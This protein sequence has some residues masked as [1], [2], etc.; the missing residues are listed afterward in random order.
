MIIT[1]GE[2]MLRLSPNGNDRFIQADAF[3]VIPGGVSPDKENLQ[4]WFMAGAWC[5]GMGSKLFP[6]EVLDAQDWTY[7]TNKCN[8]CFIALHDSPR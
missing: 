7:I 6:K 4:S 8:E 1:F 2:L 5:V 3:R